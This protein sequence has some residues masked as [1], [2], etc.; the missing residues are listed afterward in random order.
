MAAAILPCLRSFS[1]FLSVSSRSTATQSILSNRLACGLKERRC[2]D[3]YPKRS[4]GARG[5]AGG[6]ALGRR[7]PHGGWVGAASALCR[8]VSVA[9]IVLVFGHHLP[10]ARH[11]GD[12]GCGS[13]R[14]TPSVAVQH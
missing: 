5:S 9:R 14:R 2:S 8:T 11:F 10:I 7:Q 6:E 12:D 1:A 13:D 3:E 4:A